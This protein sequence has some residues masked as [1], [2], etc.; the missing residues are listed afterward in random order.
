MPEHPEVLDVPTS[1]P[2]VLDVPTS[3]QGD[4]ETSAD[5]LPSEEDE[6]EERHYVTHWGQTMALA[7]DSEPEDDS[8]M[9][10]CPEPIFNVYSNRF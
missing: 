4:T 7:T 8:R 9:R 1:D 2:E 3:Q 5:D 10:N 6:W